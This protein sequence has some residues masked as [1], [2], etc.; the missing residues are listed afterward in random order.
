MYPRYAKSVIGSKS[1]IV[2]I[3]SVAYASFVPTMN[4]TKGGKY[5]F[6]VYYYWRSPQR[7]PEVLKSSSGDP[8]T[9]DTV[10]PFSPIGP[11]SGLLS[12]SDDPATPD[13]SRPQLQGNIAPALVYLVQNAQILQKWMNADK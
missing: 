7:S 3:E 2:Q 1:V 10:G 12:P 8:V 4:T 5:L 9:L 6:L 11:L 13:F